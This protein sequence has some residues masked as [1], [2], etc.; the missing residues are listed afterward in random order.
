[1]V[2]K[3]SGLQVHSVGVGVL[4]ERIYCEELGT[5]FPKGFSQQIEQ[6]MTKIQDV[7]DSLQTSEMEESHTKEL[8]NNLLLAVSCVILEETINNLSGTHAKISRTSPVVG[9]KVAKAT[10]QISGDLSPR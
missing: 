4:S 3:Y 7:L 6:A 1:M 10:P 2:S 8:L 9:M 5:A